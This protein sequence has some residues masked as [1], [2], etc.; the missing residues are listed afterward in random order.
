VFLLSGVQVAAFG[1]A[2]PPSKEAYRLCKKIKKLKKRTK[3]N[4]GL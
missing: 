2:Y 3:S 4:K 1:L